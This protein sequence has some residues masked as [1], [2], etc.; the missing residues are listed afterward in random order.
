[1]CEISFFGWLVCCCSKLSY[2]SSVARGDMAEIGE[3]SGDEGIASGGES[4]K[5]GALI[6]KGL[7]FLVRT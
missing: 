7:Q 1:M 2:Y 4:S 5:D 6:D 3:A